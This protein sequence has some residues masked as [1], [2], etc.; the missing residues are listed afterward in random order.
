M[1]MP[2]MKPGFSQLAFV[3]P[4]ELMA[5]MREAADAAGLKLTAWIC[6]TCAAEVGVE[7]TPPK[8]GRPSAEPEPEPTPPPKRRGRPA[9]HPKK[10]GRPG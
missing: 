6:A 7:Y 2:R 10:R 4:D 5:A 3:V 9:A 1:T 8:L